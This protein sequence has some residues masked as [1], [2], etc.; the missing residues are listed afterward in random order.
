M[1]D[2]VG[3][4]LDAAGPSTGTS[5]VVLPTRRG[6]SVAVVEEGTGLPVVFLHGGVGS[7]AEWKPVLACW[8]AGHRRLAVDAYAAEDSPGTLDEPTIDDYVD[9]VLAVADHVRQPLHVVGFS[10]GGATALR[11]ATTEPAAVAS[12]TV[13]EPQAYSLLPT[14]HPDAFETITGM[15]DRWRRHVAAGRWHEAFAGFLDY[16][17]HPGWF[18]AWPE[19]RR[20]AFL[21]EQQARGDLWD[22]LFDSPLTPDA[23]TRITAPTLVVEGGR[24]AAV[25]RALC[26]VVTRKVPS[27]RH[28]VI[29][30]AGHMMPLTQPQLL[31]DAIVAHIRSATERGPSGSPG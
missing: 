22:V 6:R 4:G 11:L 26:E 20:D 16:Y 21:A 7:V 5:T 23:L 18:D 19:D 29:E 12:V 17:N 28:T 10:W 13:I 9:Q 31:A 15:R 25:E 1:T 8:P 3:G 24:A 2:D 27:C 14:E 30:G